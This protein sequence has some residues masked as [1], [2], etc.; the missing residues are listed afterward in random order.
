[1][2][3]RGELVRSLVRLCNTSQLRCKCK[4][5]LKRQ[6]TFHIIENWAAKEHFENEFIQL[7]MLNDYHEQ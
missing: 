7:M 3:E 5:E 1:M 2:G 4:K 6:Q